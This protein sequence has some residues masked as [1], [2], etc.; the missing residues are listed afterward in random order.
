MKRYE[1]LQILASMIAEQDVIV[2]NVGNTSLELHSVRPSAANLYNVN[3][4]QCTPVALG[5][6]LALP[7]RRV[8]ALDGDGNLL[9][10]LASLADVAHHTPKNLR[11][12]IFDNEAY[13]SPGGLPSAT[14]RGADLE[15]IANA[16]GIKKGQTV[17]TV[18]DFKKHL[19]AALDANE[20]SVLVAKI[21][22]GT[23]KIPHFSMDG[24][25]NK[26]IFAG[27]IEETENKPVLRLR[28]QSP[29]VE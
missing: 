23:V 26:Y 19:R 24:K 28:T 9:L 2:A 14:S 29:L 22:T 6:A 1:C 7:N 25:R 8:L 21:E 20:L 10:N 16:S 13:E 5:L 27:H 11:I 12:I 3:L 4:G 18:D 17:S 15:K